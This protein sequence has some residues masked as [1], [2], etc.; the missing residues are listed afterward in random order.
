MKSWKSCGALSRLLPLCWLPLYV[1]RC[2]T[3]TWKTCDVKEED[4]FGPQPT[5]H[6]PSPGCYFPNNPSRPF[7]TLLSF[8]D[9][10]V[11]FPAL[12]NHDAFR[13]SPESHQHRNLKAILSMMFL[14][15]LLI[16]NTHRY[17]FAAAEVKA[18]QFSRACLEMMDGKEQA[19]RCAGVSGT[20]QPHWA[21]III[22][23]P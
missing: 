19:W 10:S 20:K 21:A 15:L 14:H 22:W 13:G 8:F 17:L 1:G 16:A 4:G 9:I 5:D 23:S 3:D 11:S 2:L 7:P 18:R 12:S 6:R